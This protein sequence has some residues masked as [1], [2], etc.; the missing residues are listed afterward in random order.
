MRNESV[1]CNKNENGEKE[2]KLEDLGII[3]DVPSFS[4]IFELSPFKIHTKQTQVITFI[5][6]P[7]P[8][9][10]Q[11]SHICTGA[12]YGGEARSPGTA[13]PWEERSSVDNVAAWASWQV[14]H[15]SNC[16]T[17]VYDVKWSAHWRLCK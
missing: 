8:W 3:L 5:A 13:D 1:K 2:F 12:T 17:L 16:P 15:H 7:L 11:T 4:L 9:L 6:H 10:T 14:T